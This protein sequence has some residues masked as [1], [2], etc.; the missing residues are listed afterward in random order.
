MGAGTGIGKRPPFGERHWLAGGH[1]TRVPT[2]K[3]QG[4][5]F[6]GIAH[7]THV[8]PKRHSICVFRPNPATDSDP[9]LPPPVL[10]DQDA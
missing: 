10:A 9:K 7:R 8:D 1:K 4:V 2:H 6:L 5:T 3:Q